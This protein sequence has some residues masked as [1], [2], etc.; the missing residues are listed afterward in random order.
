[1]AAYISNQNGWADV[2]INWTSNG[3]PGS[4]YTISVGHIIGLRGDLT[5]GTNINAT[6]V[7]ELYCCH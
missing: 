1:M 2:A 5:L 7:L 6:T 4:G 3:V